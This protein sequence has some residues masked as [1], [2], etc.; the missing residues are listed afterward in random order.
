MAET[1][2]L[3]RHS[4]DARTR[5]ESVVKI[6]L[7]DCLRSATAMRHRRMRADNLTIG[8]ALLWCFAIAVVGSDVAAAENGR[9]SSDAGA[10]VVL[11]PRYGGAVLLP[12][13][14]L[15]RFVSES[16]DDGEW[17]NFTVDSNDSGRTWGEKTFAYK[18]PRAALPLFDRD[19]EY[20]V[21]PMQVRETGEPRKIAVNYFIDIWHVKT[22]DGGA[23]WEEPQVI[24]EGYVGSVNCVTQLSSGRIVVP[25]AEWI[26][27][28]PTGPPT[29]A[30]VVTCVYSDDGG[31]TWQKSPAQ[32]TAPRYTDF[33]GSGYGACEPVIIEL[34][35]GRVYMLARTE[36]GRLYESYSDDGVHWD[37]LVPSRFLGTDAPANFLR[38][39][40]G[41]MLLFMN[42][43][44]KPARLDG[45]GVYG[46][47]DVLHAAISD[48]EGQTWRGF[49]EIYRDPTRNESP[50][51]R[52]DRGTAYPMPYRAPDGNVIVMSGQG[53]AGGTVLFD[54]DWL[55]A[56]HA[57]AD[58]SNGLDNWSV[59][60]PFGPAEYWW[61]DRVQGPVLIEHPDKPDVKVLHVR[62]PDEK[63]GD[64]AVY[65]FPMGPAGALELR[66][67][68]RTGF[69]GAVIALLD[70]F[71]NPTDVRAEIEAPFTLTIRPDGHIS[72]ADQL[73]MDRWY[74]LRFEWDLAK[75]TC[76]VF[77]DDAPTVYLKQAYREPMG[78]NYV[79]I[80]ST[81]DD[82]DPAG[83]LIESVSVHIAGD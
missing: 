30:N 26:G 79:R 4:G 33:N 62:R 2:S 17:N 67:Q 81:S 20:H 46:G 77:V 38:L 29:G 32:L 37:P 13:G 5:T 70:R 44:E 50:P 73:E 60:K 34:K 15:R 35:D 25:F 72:L 6:G 40:D 71:F 9:S 80:R 54:P 22:R 19:G 21:F 28:R 76:I 18:G 83:L 55:L 1:A 39:E 75:R 69:G 53:R 52:G 36:T 16:I 42:A 57:E 3:A 65:N 74:T 63:A 45:A 43:C 11:G 58:F 23:V 61:R 10:P 56:T 24:F 78:V 31:E 7:W 41:R 49:R 64:G 27:G 68:L 8:R 14:T 82:V 59:F 51:K 48:D 66:V 12:D 47:R